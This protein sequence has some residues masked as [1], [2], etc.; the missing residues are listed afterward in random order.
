MNAV[1]HLDLRLVFV[2]SKD[3]GKD[4]NAV[5]GGKRIPGTW[6]SM[7][8]VKKAGRRRVLAVYKAESLSVRDRVN[9]NEPR[10]VSEEG[11]GMSFTTF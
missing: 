10:E 9:R 2:K 3:Q 8:R 7:S 11:H 6:K 5:D 4:G 1:A